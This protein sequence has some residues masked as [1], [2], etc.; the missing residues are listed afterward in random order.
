MPL[1][2]LHVIPAIAARYG[3]PSTAVV[4]MCRALRAEGHDVLL[5]TTDA[6]GS[7]GRVDPAASPGIDLAG[8][9]VAFFRRQASES[10]K[11][12][13][14]IARWLRDNVA[15]FDVVHIHAIFSHAC[16]AAALASRRADVPYLVRPLGTLDPWSLARHRWRKQVLLRFGGRASLEG[17][18]LMHYT[19]EAE[20]HLARQALPF[21]PAGVVV[22]LGVDEALRRA[23]AE[24]VAVD[25]P[26]YVLSMAR[27]DPKKNFEA[28]IR[29]FHRAAGPARAQWRLV[30]A[31]DGT[32]EYV[33]RLRAEAAAGAA[34]DRIEF[35]GWITGE[36]RVPLLAGA[37]LFAL[38]SHQENFGIAVAEAMACGTPVLVSGAVNLAE[39]IAAADAGWICD[40]DDASIAVALDAAA[41]SDHE[42]TQRGARARRL[43][44]QFHWPA[45]GA[46]LT[47]IYQDLVNRHERA[48]TGA[49][50]SRAFRP[51]DSWS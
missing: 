48:S 17:A 24:P 44:E 2:L 18:S 29:A 39:A 27:L 45:I 28:L 15:A 34:A 38:P 1:R 32:P 40:R 16:I 47:T 46:R 5:V 11:W 51:S 31:G 37:R 13:A 14:P 7:R 25:R 41:A 20:G 43:A 8:V 49:V 10:F 35:C 36:A 9:Q 42:R 26:P 12:S 33:A 30:I 19:T 3:G 21:L 6:D 23:A 4:G 22:P 50:D